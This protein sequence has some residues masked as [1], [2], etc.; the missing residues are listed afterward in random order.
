M[1]ELGQRLSSVTIAYDRRYA[2]RTCIH[3]R[4]AVRMYLASAFAD[5]AGTEKTAKSNFC[6]QL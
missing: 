1:T 3:I 4:P 5:E 6:S 2:V